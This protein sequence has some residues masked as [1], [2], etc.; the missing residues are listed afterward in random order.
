MGAELEGRNII[1]YI[2][3]MLLGFSKNGIFQDAL[4]L[5]YRTHTLVYFFFQ[6]FC[7]FVLFKSIADPNLFE[8]IHSCCC[9]SIKSICGQGWS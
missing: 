6:S 4:L 7:L 2:Q 9:Y 1:L 8:V 3:A 5:E